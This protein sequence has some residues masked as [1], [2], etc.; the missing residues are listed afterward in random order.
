MAV[1]LAYDV[2]YIT[3]NTIFYNVLSQPSAPQ[4][5]FGT[6]VGYAAG[7]KRR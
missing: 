1:E 6:P 7:P 4:E 5:V 2:H 3:V